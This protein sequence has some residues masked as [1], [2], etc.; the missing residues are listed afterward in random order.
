MANSRENAP[1][2][3]LSNTNGLLSTRHVQNNTSS[4]QKNNFQGKID[5]IGG[6][7]L[8]LPSKRSQE[9]P[10]QFSVFL[11]S[12]HDYT[13]RE[14]GEKG[15]KVWATTYLKQEDEDWEPPFPKKQPTT[16]TATTNET[17]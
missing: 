17:S 2:S 8:Q 11:K 12:L 4:N 1:S 10:G 13:G 3:G 7:T 5:G 9:S 16:T 6:A 14:M 15:A